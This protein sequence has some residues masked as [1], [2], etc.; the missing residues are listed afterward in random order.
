[1]C[2]RDRTQS[3]WGRASERWAEELVKEGTSP[4]CRTLSLNIGNVGGFFFFL[5]FWWMK[6]H[7]SCEL[8][9][10]VTDLV[11]KSGIRETRE[12]AIAGI[13]AR[14]NGG[15]AQGDGSGNS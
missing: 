14:G 1:M 10:E 13:L 2:F 3:A 12:Q 8:R 15:F 5:F 4:I 6:N 7:Q 11:S 9:G